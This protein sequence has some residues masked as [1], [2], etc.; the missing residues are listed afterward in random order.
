MK[1]ILSIIIIT[2]A[3]IGQVVAQQYP[4]FSNYIINGYG[5]NPAVIGQNEHIDLRTTFRTQWVGL[6]GQPQTEIVMLN[7]RVGKS[8]FNIGGNFYNDIAG[9]LKK[10]GGSG[11]FSYTKKLNEKSNLSLGVSAGYFKVNV[12]N[13]VFVEHVNDPTI[14]GAQAGVWVPD[15]SMGVYFRQQDGFFAGIGV[16]Q[17]YRKKLLFDPSLNLANPTAMVRHYYGMA[18]YTLKMNDKMKLE[19]SAMIKV[20]PSVNPQVD[21][22]VKAIF[23]NMF[24]IGGSYRTEDAVVAMAGLEYPKWYAAYSYDVTTSLLRNTSSGSHELTLGLRFGGKCKDQDNDGICDKDDKC[25]DVKGDKN[26]GTDKHGCPKTQDQAVEILK[27]LAKSIQFESGKDIIKSESFGS[28]DQVAGVVRFQQPGVPQLGDRQ[29]QQ[30]NQSRAASQTLRDARLTVDFATEAARATS[31]ASASR[32][33]A[34]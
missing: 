16:P 6:T 17:L 1:R 30:F 12:L 22:S 13:E 26:P 34:A 23:N 28:L 19:P 32:A 2:T 20:A 33:Q 29:W 24:W 11:M 9:R 14:A 31:G 7:G 27:D 8:G 4:L 21:I 15:L 10:T 18:G 5:Y 25:P 3:L